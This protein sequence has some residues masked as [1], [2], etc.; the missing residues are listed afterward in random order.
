LA[1]DEAPSKVLQRRSVMKALALLSGGLD[2]ILATKLVLD[3]GIEVIAVTFILPVV[4]EKVDYAG[5]TVERFGIPQIRVEMGDDYLEVIRNPK[6]G[7]GSGMN[8]CIDCRIYMLREAKRIANEIGAKFIVT[9]D[10]LGER[11]MSQYRKALLLEEEE[12]GLEGLILRPLSAKLLP[13][14]IPE[15]E[16]WV[17]RSALLAISG[18]SRKP[19]IALAEQ[20]GLQDAYPSPAGGCLLTH[21][22]FASK[23]KDLFEHEENVTTRDIELLRIGRH[24]RAASSKIVVGRNEAEN[25]LLLELKNPGDY[26]FEVPGYGSPITILEQSREKE[27]IELAAKLTARYSDAARGEE[28][29]VEYWNAEGK[30]SIVVSP[31]SDDEVEQLRI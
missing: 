19:Q 2:S 17:D 13:E 5:K 26:A 4:V 3:Q 24:F 8:P 28:V 14:T 25:E 9:G 6:Y 15:R 23:V 11:P 16:G 29:L 10:V 18:K 22:E 12:A 21:K 30:A 1:N 31:L 20:F 7:Y 27:A